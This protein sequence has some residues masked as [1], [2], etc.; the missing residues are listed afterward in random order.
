MK[1]VV[2]PREQDLE[3][4]FAELAN[5]RVGALTIGND[6]LLASWYQQIRSLA[7]RHKIAAVLGGSGGR[8]SL[9][10]GALAAYGPRVGDLYQK[11]GIYAGQILKGTKPGDLPVYYPTEFDLI[12]NLRS[13]NSLGL[14]VPPSLLARADEVIE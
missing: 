3:A 7:T 9:Y 13:A 8:Q 2:V 1:I 11:I 12:I 6:A 14:T 5:A 4:A 10:E